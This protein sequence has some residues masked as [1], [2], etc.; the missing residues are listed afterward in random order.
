MQESLQVSRTDAATK[1][2]LR[3]KFREA[4]SAFVRKA[5]PAAV[6]ALS[7]NLQ[8][9]I[10]DLGL[11][12][13]AVYSPLSD[14]AAFELRGEFFYPRLTGDSMQF[15]KPDADHNFQPGALGIAEP[16]PETSTPLDLSRPALICCPAVAL[17]WQ[18]HR[19]G[20]GKGYY[21]RF[22]SC[23]PRPLRVG[24]AFQIQVSKDPLPVDS[25]DQP[26]DWIVTE[27][28][29]LRTSKRSP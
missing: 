27:E 25:W 23:H 14:E 3:Q 15:L 8:R 2:A 13:I 10:E 20:M 19:L 22:F 1:G 29:I 4:R 18:G 16:E 12:Q 7:Q 28:M 5:G 26:L 24:V 6:R 9:I 17:D 21:D 11:P